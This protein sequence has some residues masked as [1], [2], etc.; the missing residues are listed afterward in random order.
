MGSEVARAAYGEIV[1]L[2]TRAGWTPRERVL[3]LADLQ[4]RLFEEETREEVLFFSSLFA[5]ISYVGHKY[6][7][8][9][10]A[11]RVIH[12]FRRW[13]AYVRNGQC[14]AGAKEVAL[15]VWA[16]AEAV[17]SMSGEPIPPAVAACFPNPGEWQFHAPRVADH[18]DWVRLTAVANYPEAHYLE[19]YDE[20]HPDKLVRVRYHL[21]ERNE[22][23]SASLQLL[24]KVFP[25][26]VTMHL[27][28][29]NIDQAGDYC[30]RG[31]VIE[32]DYLVDVSVV[33]D[34]FQPEG[35]QVLGFLVKK[36]LSYETST[37]A[38]VGNLANYFLDRLLHEPEADFTQLL[39][40]SF[41]LFP[42]VYAP[43][44]DAEV[45][46]VRQRAQKHYA[47]LRYMA[48]GGL[49]DQG[50]EP[51]HCVLEPTFFS[52]QY[53]LQGRLDL[54]YRNGDNAAIV[55]LKS[56]QVYRPNSH[57]IAR[58]HFTQTLLYDL[59]VGSVF[60]AALRPAKYILYS[61]ADDRL[62]RFAP[63]VAA[64]QWE[65]LQVRNQLVAIERLLMG[66]RPGQ[67]CVPLFE[68]LLRQAASEGSGSFAAR[69]MAEFAG[70][71]HS[72]SDVE[73]KYFNAFVGF[74][75]RE[76]WLAKVGAEESDTA[77][78]NAALWRQSLTEK[79]EAFAIL[80]QLEI[81]ENHAHRPE[82][83]IVFRRTEQTHPLA[84]FRAGDLAVLYPA[85]SED[86]NVLRHQVIK[87]TI[88][89]ITP[90][91][92][93]V[94]LRARQFNLKPFEAH[95]RWNLEPDILESG[96]LSLY[97]SLYEWAKAPA[98]VRARWLCPEKPSEPSAQPAASLT[99]EHIATAPHF[100]LVWGPP[101]TGKTSIV[102]RDVV[103]W[104]LKHTA[105]NLVL[106]AYT[107]RAVDEMC[108]VLE[109][110]GEDYIRLGT[111]F[112]TGERFRPRL[113]SQRMA[114]A[115]SRAELLAI[116][117]PVR[118]F[119]GTVS[120]FAQSENLLKVKT[121]Q[122]LIVDEASQIV[123]PQ[124]IGLL[125]RFEHVVLIG[126]HYQ[127]PAVVAQAPMHTRV[128]DPDL[129]ALGLTDL[130]G[131][132]FER[133]YRYCT[134][135]TLHRHYGQLC[136]QGRMHVDIMAFPNERFYRGGLRTLSEE[137]SS[138]QHRPLPSATGV[139][140]HRLSFI[141][142]VSNTALPH[143]RI[144][145]EEAH[146]IAQLVHY[147]VQ[148]AHM[149]HQPWDPERSLGIIT[150]WRAQIAQ[151]R[152]A[153]AQAGFDP[154]AYTVDTVERYQGGARDIIL[155]S[156]CVH[157]RRQLSRL[158]SHSAE[159]VDRKLNVALTRARERV[160]MVGNPDVLRL[161]EHYRAFI[162]RYLV[163]PALF[164]GASEQIFPKF[165]R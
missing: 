129:R 148:E 127:L 82:P 62:L 29:V 104:V 101:G 132:Y 147:F 72:L 49:R 18:R 125:T 89:D 164:S 154:N 58:S 78:G 97:R 15:G 28:D 71:Y 47:N 130:R 102:L 93:R 73:K 153:L 54:F 124:L 67:L 135:H 85:D 3:A 7:I 143:Q 43:M 23:F 4:V 142:V 99:A 65:A 69:E 115:Q 75:A 52:A 160:V 112:A 163:S 46:E 19:G 2:A 131:A 61:G 110:L 81:V 41:R 156:C 57:G 25:L 33:A 96:F 118:L 84:N 80:A 83:I 107:N 133:L 155:I 136:R 32:P 149:S 158:V 98:D 12:H 109:E 48:K 45:M 34:R 38:L 95:R 122:R 13:A 162:D 60:G 90:Q 5:R 108:E 151:I 21:P 157:D 10:E 144:A 141:P 161:D 86:D 55:E 152:E 111:V 94:Q 70:V 36:F 140:L 59:L 126:D 159:G 88:I 105:D 31:F 138:R 66:I 11:L 8:S 35:V 6:R 113:L 20:A 68:R 63:T 116:L 24:Q 92:I 1:R 50:I 26:P 165:V 53:G 87:C 40:E 128:A 44:S 106:L 56:G 117:Q 114:T 30:P 77:G 119:V 64:E 39:R 121:F 103:D 137:V 100:F 123:E 120:S 9:E 37:A 16:L 91:V 150:P 22:H 134:Q 139:S 76:H 146:C 42:L 51:E 74:I 145:P 14:T 79:Q 17:R 27:L